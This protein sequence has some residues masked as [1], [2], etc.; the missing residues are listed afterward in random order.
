MGKLLL[1]IFFA[2]PCC[3]IFRMMTPL[4]LAHWY[5]LCPCDSF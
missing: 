4:N 3:F 5:S 1:E 2:F